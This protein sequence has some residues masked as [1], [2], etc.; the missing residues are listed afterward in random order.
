MKIAAEM[1]LTQK[2]KTRLNCVRMYLGVTWLSK[3]STLND[4]YIQTHILQHKGDETEY[5]PE[6]EKPYQ[7][8]PNTH[9]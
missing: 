9:S 7:P 8:K 1:Q 2:Q 5:T 4:K 6:Q 3:I